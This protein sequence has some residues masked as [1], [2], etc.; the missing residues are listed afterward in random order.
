MVSKLHIKKGL[1]IISVSVILV[2][3][4]NVYFT[5]PFSIQEIKLLVASKSVLFRALGNS[6]FIDLAKSSGFI[7]SP[8]PIITNLLFVLLLPHSFILAK[9]PN[10]LLL[11]GVLLLYK[12]ILVE[13]VLGPL[14]KKVRLIAL[15]LLATSPWLIQTAIYNPFNLISLIFFIF[16]V[17]YLKRA[18]FDKTSLKKDVYLL[19]ASIIFLS[20]S[21]F[22]GILTAAF[23]FLASIFFYFKTK[24]NSRKN[25]IAPLL[26]TLLLFSL[27]ILINKDY[28]LFRLNQGSLFSLIQ[29]LRIFQV[30]PSS[31]ITIPFFVTLSSLCISLTF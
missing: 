2:L 27:N 30:A 31:P 3:F 10:I 22:Q 19:F 29:G 18:F 13:N 4:L 5:T 24:I 26:A 25:F 6:N 21:S 14:S 9:V 17:I 20:L 7:T 1:F 11:L 23:L 28:M 12:N 15:V 8:I 16:S